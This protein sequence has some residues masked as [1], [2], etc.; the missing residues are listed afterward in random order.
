MGLD[1]PVEHGLLGLAALVGR[2]GGARWGHAPRG[3]QGSCPWVAERG[4]AGRPR[5]WSHAGPGRDAGLRARTDTPWS[6][7]Q[8]PADR[9]GRLRVRAEA[10]NWRVGK[11][12]FVWETGRTASSAGTST[13][14]ART[15]SERSISR[16]FP[17]EDGKAS[18]RVQC[19][20]QQSVRHHHRGAGGLR[21][22]LRRALPRGHGPRAL[23]DPP[24]GSQSPPRRQPA[25]A[26]AAARGVS[27]VWHRVAGAAWRR[28]GPDQG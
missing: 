1:G 5:G 17:P 19:S 3:E 24:D 16:R 20:T 14:Q 8:P 25:G 4:S 26:R 12:P 6:R 2:R 23:R 11:Y 13:S 7:E 18:D 21:P 27:R 15:R 9:R 28:A 22:G 10:A